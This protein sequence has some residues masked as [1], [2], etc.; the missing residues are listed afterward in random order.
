MRLAYALAALLTLALPGAAWAQEDGP[1]I[2]C[3]EVIDADPAT[4]R[5]RAIEHFNRA[6][7]LYLDG[8]YE[9]CIP[10]YISSYCLLPNSAAAYNLANAYRLH[11][12][13]HLSIHNQVQP[14][15]GDALPL[16]EERKRNLLLQLEAAKTQFQAEC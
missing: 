12:D 6:R 15:F 9:A 8:Q 7:V 5:E 3:G 11:F 13:D 1:E 10:E 4:V 14:V 2:H 16:V